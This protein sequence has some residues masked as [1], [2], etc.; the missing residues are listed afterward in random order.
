MGRGFGGLEEGPGDAVGDLGDAAEDPAGVEG[1][2]GVVGD[3]AGA[4][5]DSGA[6]VDLAG[7]V[8]GP[9]GAVDRSY[10]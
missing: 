1:L 7:A 6:V 2:V 3:L 5:V 8:V 9:V 4:V 10:R